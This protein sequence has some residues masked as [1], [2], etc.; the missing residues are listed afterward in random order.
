MKKLYKVTVDD[1]KDSRP[2]T[3]WIVAE[4]FDEA[5]AKARL[6]HEWDDGI[7]TE[8]FAEEVVA[9]RLIAEGEDLVL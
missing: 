7:E 5:A 8:Y 3:Q 4:T 2:R 1:L 9:I 6:E